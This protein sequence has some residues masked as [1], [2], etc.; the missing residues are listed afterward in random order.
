MELDAVAGSAFLRE[1]LDDVLLA[2]MLFI[3]F[4]PVFL[5]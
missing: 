3:T 5:V 2:E 1:V 4:C